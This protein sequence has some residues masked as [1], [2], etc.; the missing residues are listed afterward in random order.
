MSYNSDP[1]LWTFGTPPN[2]CNPCFDTGLSPEQ[3]LVTFSGIE[4]GDDWISS[5]PPPPNGS[6]ILD[7]ISACSWQATFAPW[8]ML[9]LASS[10]S[11]LEI[12]H[13][14]IGI[15]FLRPF[16]PSC[17]TYFSNSRTS[18]IGRKFFSGWGITKPAQVGVPNGVPVIMDLTGIPAE[19]GTFVSPRPLSGQETVYV[20]ARNRDSSNIH[21]K[22]STP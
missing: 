17:R 10:P 15:I 21:V 14:T 19:A 7:V 6:F 8:T 9:Y 13:P 5:D 3:I 11:D 20:F 4:R 12:S 2:V 22:V 18:P 1:T 16:G